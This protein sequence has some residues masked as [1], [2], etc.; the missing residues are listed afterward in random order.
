MM[1]LQQAL[2]KAVSV[3]QVNRLHK[4]TSKKPLTFASFCS[5]IEVV[6]KRGKNNQILYKESDFTCLM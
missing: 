4:K 3:L 5:I 2:D 1:M 6:G